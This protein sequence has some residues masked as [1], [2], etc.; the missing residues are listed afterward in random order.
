MTAP[1]APEAEAAMQRLASSAVEML[2]SM[3]RIRREASPIA[4]DGEIAASI[5]ASL[6]RLARSDDEA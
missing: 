4:S 3:I 1:M 6:S 2:D 5:I